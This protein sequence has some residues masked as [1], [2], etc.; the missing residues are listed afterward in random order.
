M[1]CA[2]SNAGFCDECAEWTP[3]FDKGFACAEYGGVRNITHAFKYGGKA[4]YGEAISEM[5]FDRLRDEL[6]EIDIVAPVP[7]HKDKERK[8]GYNQAD[9]LASLL[10]KKLLLPYDRGVLIRKRATDA[11]SRLG[12][13]VRSENIKGAFRAEPN[14][15]KALRGRKILLVDDIYTTG[16]TM[17]ECALALKAAGAKAVYFVV[18]ATGTDRI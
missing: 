10:A 9:V 5:M 7:M 18:F 6:P 8:R 17:N 13:S 12:S 4:Y 15:A 16:S 1:L 3:A 11:M 14:R 2:S